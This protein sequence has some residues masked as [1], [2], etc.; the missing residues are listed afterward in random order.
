MIFPSFWALVGLAT[1]LTV[2]ALLLPKDEKHYVENVLC[3]IMSVFMWF[4]AALGGAS[5][6]F[7]YTHLFENAADNTY[8]VV[9]GYYRMQGA[10]GGLSWLFLGM[11]ILMLI[12]VWYTLF[13]QSMEAVK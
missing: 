3:G 8:K 4:F 11:G 9:E 6:D 2:I 10:D 1:L 7:P 13:R 12:Y 5:L